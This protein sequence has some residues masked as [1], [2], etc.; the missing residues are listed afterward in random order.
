MKASRIAAAAAAI[1]L[2]LVACARADDLSSL[3]ADPTGGAALDSYFT[4]G[5]TIGTLG[6]GLELGYRFNSFI[7]VRGGFNWIGYNLNVTGGV[8]SYAI[9]ANWFNGSALVDVYPFQSVLRLTAGMHFGRPTL[10]GQYTPVGTVTIGGVVYPAATVGRL[11]ADASF[12][13]PVQ[14][15]VGLGLEGSPFSERIVLGLDAGVVILSNPKINLT[16]STGLIP[17]AQ[18]Q[19]D[20]ASFNNNWRK[21]PV[22]PVIQ[23]SVKYKF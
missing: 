14:P 13:S 3:K 10:S 18:L 16:S 15:Y 17:A 12:S 22:Y 7:G 4:A 21:Y 5:A 2:A 8:N 9:A 11:N 1:S 20:A 19:A 6:P 23:A